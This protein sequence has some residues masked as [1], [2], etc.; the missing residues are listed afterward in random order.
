M[1]GLL[2]LAAWS[3]AHEDW[4]NE[5]SSTPPVSSTMHALNALPAAELEPALEDVPAAVVLGDLVPHAAKAKA[6]TETTA[7]IF[8][9][10]LKALSPY[11]HHIREMHQMAHLF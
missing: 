7:T 9:D 8:I 1:L 4:L 2:L 5:R 3:P 10:D 6:A 11:V